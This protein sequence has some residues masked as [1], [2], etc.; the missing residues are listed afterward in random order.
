M[1]SLESLTQE[2]LSRI[3]DRLRYGLRGLHYFAVVEPA[4][5]LNWKIAYQRDEKKQ[6]VSWHLHGLVWGI[7]K[8]RMQKRL[9][10][11]RR[12]GWY[13]R[14]ERGLRPTH[15]KVV[16]LGRLPRTVGYL[17][18]S[19]ISAYRVSAVDWI[20]DGKSVVDKNGVVQRKFKQ[21]KSEL[22]PGERLTLYFTMRHLY[23]DELALAGGEGR[24]LLAAAKRAA[25]PPRTPSPGVPNCVYWR[26]F[27]S[28]R[29]GTSWSARPSHQD[30]SCK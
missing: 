23:L 26:E 1:R 28:H 11:L 15:V 3:K 10:E 22:R 5:Y 2:D 16:Q 4:L 7:S 12:E 18:K 21:T 29:R 20:R 17:L 9:R 25:R 6:C 14:L 27:F 19:P 30:R 24:G 13:E 8:S